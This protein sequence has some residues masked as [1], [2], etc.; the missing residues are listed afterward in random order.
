VAAAVRDGGSRA[1]CGAGRLGIVLR[2]GRC[3]RSGGRRRVRLAAG[4]SDRGT[5]IPLIMMSFLMAGTFVCGS[6]AASAAFLA[7]RSL[8]GICD[9]AAIAAAS[10]FDRAGTAGRAGNR[11][12]RPDGRDSLPLDA[13]EVERAVAA[14]RGAS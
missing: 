11:G 2:L 14:Y 6:I 4:G 3:G 10:A 1:A 8:A 5:T 9:G 13:G 12:S 7:Q